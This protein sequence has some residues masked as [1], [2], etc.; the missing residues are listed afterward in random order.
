[1]SKLRAT[2]TI[3]RIDLTIVE[4]LMEVDTL[5]QSIT[6]WNEAYWQMELDTLETWLLEGDKQEEEWQEF[7][8]QWRKAAATWT[9]TFGLGGNKMPP[10]R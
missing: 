8:G 4:F 1:M 5:G 10:K 7:N 9:L 2:M 6:E 3:S